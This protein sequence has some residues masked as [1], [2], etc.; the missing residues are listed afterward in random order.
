MTPAGLGKSTIIRS[1]RRVHRLGRLNRCEPVSRRALR[2]GPLDV[3]G[4]RPS[5]TTL[6][7]REEGVVRIYD[8]FFD[9]EVLLSTD[10]YIRE[11][12]AARTSKRPMSTA[13]YHYLWA[14]TSSS[15]RRALGS[16]GNRCSASRTSAPCRSTRRP[17]GLVHRDERG[18]AG[19]HR[20][21]AAVRPS[22]DVNKTSADRFDAKPRRQERHLD[23]RRPAARRT[24]YCRRSRRSRKCWASAK[25]GM[26]TTSR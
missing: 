18:L 12:S 8:I 2:V 17:P 4:G 9:Y 6:E 1:S 5:R 13:E 10:A 3:I 11:V 19:A 25:R 24:S 16:R 22:A 14:A 26:T 7:L 21:A 15:A 20:V 23:H